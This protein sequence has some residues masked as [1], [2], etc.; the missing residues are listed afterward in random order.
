MT[1]MQLGKSYQASGKIVWVGE[2]SD[3]LD[4]YEVIIP[5]QSS[6]GWLWFF[7]TQKLK[8]LGIAKTLCYVIAIIRCG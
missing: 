7:S 3:Q 5:A 2:C 6:W 4:Y 1:L 8:Y